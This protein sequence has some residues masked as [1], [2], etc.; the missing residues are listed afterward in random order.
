VKNRK[1]CVNAVSPGPIATPMVSSMGMGLREE[2]VE[3]F[4]TSIVNAVPLRRMDNPMKLQKLS[5]FVG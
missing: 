3:Q 4:K 2:K 1:I 5:R